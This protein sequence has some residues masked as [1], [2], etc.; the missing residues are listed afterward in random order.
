MKVAVLCET[1]QATQ[2]IAYSFDQSQVHPDKQVRFNIHEWAELKKLDVPERYQFLLDAEYLILSRWYSPDYILEI[3]REARNNGK[4]VYLHLDDYLFSVPQSIG[5]KKWQHYSSERMLEA[6]YL[7]SELSD[8]I[9]ASTDLLAAQIKSTLPN[10]P[11]LVLPY[12]RSFDPKHC[13]GRN[14]PK[15]PYPVVGYMGTQTH[16]DDLALI[17]PDIDELLNRNSSLVFE[18]FGLEIPKA[19][20]Q[21]YPNRCSTLVKV[22]SYE[23]FQSALS[24]LGWWLGL[25]PLAKNTFNH[26]K[27]NTKFVEYVQAG[28]P[29]LASDFGPYA[30]TPSISSTLSLSDHF[31]WLTNIEQVLFSRQ[32][33][34]LLFASQ[35]EYCSQFSDSG[36]LVEFY[37]AIAA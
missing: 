23:Q 26:C 29:V 19:L 11:I 27:T 16:A 4:K 25:A 21:K 22:D 17:L 28:I 14:C 10:C 20:A 2:M 37:R 32:K 9:I 3:I 36:L 1:L 13:P 6:L 33:R 15:R 30:N 8:G 24:S 5:I 7:T 34:D 12:W 18:T 35:L 31:S